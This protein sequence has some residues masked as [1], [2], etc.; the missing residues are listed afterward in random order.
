MT[1][2]VTALKAI[3]PQPMRRPMRREARRS[4]R[5]GGTAGGV[6]VVVMTFRVGIASLGSHGGIPPNPEGG[7]PARQAENPLPTGVAPSRSEAR[8]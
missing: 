6:V 3:H 8:T 5:V 4:G 7:S 1:T 2:M